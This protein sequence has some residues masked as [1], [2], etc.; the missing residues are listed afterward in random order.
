MDYHGNEVTPLSFDALDET[1]AL[2]RAEGVQAVAI[3]LLHAYANT[4]HEVALAAEVQ[5]RWPDVTVVASHQITREWREYERTNTTVLSAYVQPKAQRYLEKL[6]TG[7]KDKGYRGQL[8]IMQSNCGVDSLQA[9]K[10]VP[11]TMVESGPASGFWG[12][13]EL[14]RII[15]NP[16]SWHSISA[17]PRQSAR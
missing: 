11:I 12:A 14:G 7:L 2:F 6:E 10:A 9:T 13:A 1:L 15:E 16:M 5:K 8:F 3:C 4:A 17:A